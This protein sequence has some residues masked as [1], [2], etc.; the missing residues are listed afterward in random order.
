MVKMVVKMV[1]KMVMKIVVRVLVKLVV[2][3]LVSVHLAA[4]ENQFTG[5]KS[6]HIL[7]P[8]LQLSFC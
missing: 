5:T 6:L 8:A 1:L 4:G 7:C 2:R 3:M